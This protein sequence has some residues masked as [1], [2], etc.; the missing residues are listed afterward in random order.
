MDHQSMVEEPS[1]EQPHV[2]TPFARITGIVA[3]GFVLLLL[4]LIALKFIIK[5]VH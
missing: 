2:I 5:F 4:V 3:R 1:Q